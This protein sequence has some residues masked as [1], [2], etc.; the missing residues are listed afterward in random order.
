MLQGHVFHSFLKNDLRQ[1]ASYIL[2]QFLGGMPPAIFLFLTG[3][4]LAFL[5]DGRERQGLPAS[6]R[7][8]A[9]TRRAGYLFGIAFLFR[10]QLWLFGRP[11][12]PWQDVFKVDILN[13]MGFAV[14]LMSFLAVLTTRQRVRVC[15]I[16]GLAIAAASPL[17][18]QM[19]WTGV[20]PVLSHY[21]VPDYNFFSF[22]PWAAYLA[23]GMSAGSLIR[24]VRDEEMDRTMQWSAILG[25]MLIL[26]SQYVSG[27]PYSIYAK[28]EYWLNSPAQVLTKLGVLLLVLPLGFLW[29]RYGATDRWSLVRQ[30]GTTSLVVYW[31]HIELVYG[32]W[33]YFWKENLDVAQTVA[34]AVLV[35][36]LMLCFSL[37]RSNWT[38]LRSLIPT[39]PWYTSEPK[40]VSGD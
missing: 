10:L 13:C 11:Y 40:R 32:R 25:G 29:T 27:L 4:T 16:A 1:G 14:A 15:A 8:W 30:F 6:A 23:F 33:L 22:F 31:V 38:K 3:V 36:L 18:S 26:A 5:M 9:A 20:P 34:A 19:D 24:V 17:V 12:S 21:I 39:L 2:S 37:A 28:S 7:I 35:I